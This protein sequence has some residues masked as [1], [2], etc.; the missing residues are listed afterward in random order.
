MI[1]ILNDS[2]ICSRRAIASRGGEILKF[3]GDGLLAIFP[4]GEPADAPRAAAERPRRRPRGSGTTRRVARATGP[5]G[6]LPQLAIVIAL[7]YGTVIYGNVGSVNRLDFTVI[8][9]AVN[10]VSRIEAVAKSRD[11]PLIVSDDFA[12]AYGRPM[13]RW[14]STRCEASSSRT[15][16]SR[17]KFEETG[18]SRLC[19]GR[20]AKG[21]ARHISVPRT[22][23]TAGQSNP[24]PRPFAAGS[25]AAGRRLSEDGR[26]HEG[27]PLLPE[28]QPPLD[29]SLRTFRPA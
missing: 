13:S 23:G 20:T 1:A 3:I 18:A 4:V 15:N 7:H 14:A 12:N 10:L 25:G 17:R 21:R 22:A 24:R 16:C 19:H 6:R 11:L 26:V 9:P 8:G 5:E 29:L 2:S 27:E 28:D